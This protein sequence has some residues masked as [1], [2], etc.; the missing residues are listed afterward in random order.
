[1]H[2]REALN[3]L[4]QTYGEQVFDVYIERTVKFP[5]STI[6]EG[7]G[8]EPEPASILRYDPTSKYAD[9]Y[10]KLA[11]IVIGEDHA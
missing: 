8:R 6:V 7:F 11:E 5:D 9:A 3:I 10:R 4:Q 2:S 1:V